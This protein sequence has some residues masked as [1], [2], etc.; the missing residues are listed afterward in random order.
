MKNYLFLITTLL[1]VFSLNAQDSIPKKVLNITKAT[2]APKIDAF[3][4]DE[5]WQN[6]EEA[7]D[8]VQ[9]RPA[10]GILENPHQKTVV[11]MTYDDN[12][13]YFLA[14]LYDNPDDILKQFTQRDDFGSADFF[15]VAINPNNDAQND[16]EFV[17][18]AS[19]TQADAVASPTSGEDFGWNAVWDSAVRIVDD[20]WIVEIKI[21]Y[22]AL[23]FS[24]KEIQTWGIQFHRRFRKTDFQYAWNPIDNTKGYHSLYHGEVHGIKKITPP[25]RLS[26]YPFTSGLVRT[27]DDNTD[28]DFSLGMD[29]KYGLSE[30]FT[31]DATLI[32]DFSQAGFDNV[33]LNLGPFEQRFSEQRQFF[34]EGIDLF[35]KG[36]LFYTRR[37]GGS[38]SYY[39]ELNENEEVENFPNEVKVLNALKVSGRT[40]NGL[41]VGIFN[42][43]TKKTEV[44]IEDYNT[45]ETRKEVVEP[46]SNYNIL[47]V[48]KQFNQNSS[49]SLINTNVTRNGH[50]RDANVTAGLVNI[51]NKRNTD[52]FQA[53]IKMSYIND[54]DYNETGFSGYLEYNDVDGKNRIG[55][56]YR[57]ADDKYDINDMG[58][59]RR[60][61]YSDFSFYY[62]YRIFEPTERLNNFNFE[63]WLRYRNRFKDQSYRGNEIGFN[64]HATNKKLLTYGFR[65]EIGI[66]KQ[67]DYWEPRTENRYFIYEN[68]FSTRGFIS[69]NY[70]KKF[71]INL[72]A[73]FFTL[74]EDGRDVFYS[75]FNITPRFRFNDKFSINYSLGFNKGYG[76]RGY[77]TT[78]DDRIIF[79]ERKQQT[80]ENSIN[81]SYNFDSFHGLSLTFRN[82][83]STVTYKHELATLLQNGNL[84]FNTGYNVDNIDYNPNANF[85]TWNLDLK[86][87]WQFAPGSQLSALYRNSLFNYDEASEDS[88]RDSI[89][90]LFDQ[91]IEH[92]FSLR[93]VYFIDYN[94]V[95]NLLKKKTS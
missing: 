80:I 5:V 94:N 22:A 6:A 7:K 48:D 27:Y 85:N 9:F 89:N 43:I 10:M 42:A 75:F 69:T 60:N 17:V 88:Y 65:A 45:N 20:G 29:V 95:K 19:G 16:T 44:T 73:G 57:F 72:N 32:P 31:L 3:S 40:K 67:Y 39:P 70:N 33:E 71:S 76:G 2:K 26:F 59:Q 58:I 49:V 14:Y 37:I 34:T 47:V 28:T 53:A 87:S 74:F 13:V 51:T 83:W 93:L 68:E 84:A 64:I 92:I 61:D 30:N 21:P 36:D 77:V 55:G 24:N 38:P 66:G 82:Y 54:F 81:A 18:F 46:L 78:L 1:F 11:K 62:Q 41:G 63:S 35:S 50:F 79:G 91:P 4:N 52:N 86:Y 8:F 15:L 90:T 56:N 23:R 12:A 25:T